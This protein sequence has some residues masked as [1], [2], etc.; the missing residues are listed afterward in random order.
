MVAKG[1][2]QKYGIDYDKTFSP[3]ARMDTIRAVLAIAIQNQWPLYQMDV[4][5]A[6]FNG[7]LEEEV[8]VDQ[9]P[10]YT[11]K[12]HEDKVFKMKKALYGLKQTPRDCDSRIDSYLVNNG[13]SRSNNEPNMYVK[14]EQCKMLIV[15]L[16]VDDMIY[17]GNLI[18]ED[19]R[20]IMKK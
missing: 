6:F 8:Y 14:I 5:S 3:V 16:H 2:A 13:F 12:G 18:P 7:I 9:P 17:T 19:F 15:C 1:Y 4:K 20:T 11:V 10:G